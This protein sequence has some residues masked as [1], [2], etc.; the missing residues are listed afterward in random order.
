MRRSQSNAKS[1]GD[2]LIKKLA[3]LSVLSTVTVSGIIAESHPAT[4]QA[5]YWNTK[6][7][8]ESQ[9]LSST[10]MNYLNTRYL[11]NNA[12]RSVKNLDQAIV[13]LKQA[14]Q[15]DDTDPLPHYLLGLCLNIQGHY[16]Q[17]LDMLRRAYQ[18]DPRE[19]EVL[20]AT[21]M[22]QYLNGKYDKAIQLYEKLLSEQPT[23]PGP[24]HTLLG[25][26]YM[27]LGDFDKA[28]QHFIKAKS[29]TP[30]SPLPYQGMAILYYLAGDL[31]QSRQ[32]GE[33]ALSL[34]E[35]PLLSLLLARIEYLEGNDAAASMRMKAWKK[36]SGTKYIPRSMVTMGFSKQHDFRLDPF[37]HEIYD[38]PG[39]LLARSINDEKKEKRR[40]SYTKQGKVEDSLSKTR[41]MI[42][43][44]SSDYV[45]LHENGMLQLSN[46]DFKG[47]VSSF[48]DVLRMCPNC[49]V[50][51]IYLAEAFSKSGNIE[52]AKRSLEYYTKTY[53]RQNLA[54]QYKAIATARDTTPAAK[55][56]APAA[57][58]FQKLLLP[59]ERAPGD[60]SPKDRTPGDDSEF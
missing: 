46:G 58:G 27:R 51:F 17:A 3:V 36:Q 12:K 21:G 5:Q 1:T 24:V 7:R 13:V 59:G 38:S 33:H 14:I 57:D 28:A 19:K 41:K 48:Q 39:A 56:P 25:F 18:L 53:P 34:G 22:T 40:K 45:A 6:Q 43:I 20:L 8:A 2:S 9:R 10:A 15:A 49:R 44:N 35:Y 55:T 29:I 4:A 32:A 47:A 26:S 52:D 54:P 11:K 42:G 50:D 31:T 23:N 60:N 37:E 16:E 30:G